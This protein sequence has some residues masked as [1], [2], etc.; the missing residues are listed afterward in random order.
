M[1]LGEQWKKLLENLSCC[2]GERKNNFENAS[3]KSKFNIQD[4]LFRSN[5]NETGSDEGAWIERNILSKRARKGIVKKKQMDSSEEEPPSKSPKKKNTSMNGARVTV[6]NSSSSSDEKTLLP[7]K[8]KAKPKS[9]TFS[10]SSSSAEENN[11]NSPVASAKAQPKSSTSLNPK[12]R[13]IPKAKAKSSKIKSSSSD[14][15]SESSSSDS[16]TP[17]QRGTRNKMASNGTSILSLKNTRAISPIIISP[18]QQTPANSLSPG[19]PGIMIG[20]VRTSSINSVSGSPNMLSNG[21]NSSSRAMISGIEVSPG[22]GLSLEELHKIRMKELIKGMH[23][24]LKKPRGD[25]KENGGG[26]L[27]QLETKLPWH[28][29]YFI[30]T[31]SSLTYWESQADAKARKNMKGKIAFEDI[32]SVNVLPDGLCFE[33][34]IQEDGGSVRDFVLQAPNTDAK[35]LWVDRLKK[36]I[37]EV[38]SFM[39][40]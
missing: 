25:S 4:M 18:T 12:D 33:M 29:R 35:S 3:E 8:N 23:G 40:G 39:D 9:R 14:S 13:S 17:I 34:I 37:S 22:N 5:G 6:K 2:N 20:T 31:M 38:Q 1:D 32:T 21:P 19:S 36:C 16:D 11:S 28:D 24:W 10:P 7:S 26:L 27:H 30:A 15:E